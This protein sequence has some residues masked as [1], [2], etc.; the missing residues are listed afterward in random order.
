M[1]NIGSGFELSIKQYANYVAKSIGF[2]S[3]IIFDGNKKIDG[4]KR[5]LVDCFLAKKYGWRS[6]F[7]FY[8][9]FEITY[10]DFLN[11]KKTY[12]GM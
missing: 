2:K 9:G 4:T 8:K 3:K 11:N 1:I 12:L 6:K 10:Q 7:N 5:K